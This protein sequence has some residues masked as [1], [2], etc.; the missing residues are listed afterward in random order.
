MSFLFN[1][2]LADILYFGGYHSLCHMAQ[3]LVS[4]ILSC[5]ATELTSRGLSAS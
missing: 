3:Q 5:N 4:Y 2:K 1:A